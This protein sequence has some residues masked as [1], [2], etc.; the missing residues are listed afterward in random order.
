MI[1]AFDVA[2]QVVA[3]INSKQDYIRQFE[4]RVDVPQKDELTDRLDLTVRC[5]PSS[6]SSTPETRTSDDKD[7]S[8][9]VAVQQHLPQEERMQAIRELHGLVGEI[10]DRLDRWSPE[11]ASFFSITI[12]PIFEPN[13]LI[14]KSLF[15][16]VIILEYKPC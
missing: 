12:D 14:E 3:H 8:V 7:L 5:L 11:E 15:T 16:S 13:H 1:N 6:L 2:D 4:A 9:N 10:Y